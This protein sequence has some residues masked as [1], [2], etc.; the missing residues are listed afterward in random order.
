DAG[1]FN[2]DSATGAVTF[3]VAPDFEAPTDANG[4]NAY[5]VIVHANDGVHDTT[6]AVTISVTDTNDVEPTIT[7][8]ATGSEAENAST[9]NL[10]YQIIPTHPGTALSPSTTLFRSDAGQFNI[11]SA[12]GAVTF[13]VAPDFEAPTDANGDNAY[14]VIVHANDGVHD[15][16]QAVTIS[17]T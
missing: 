13:K 14:Q 10:L 17:V 5:Q 9:P 2:I 4:D 15:T 7:S 3:K 8:T 12:T 16:T 6:Q 11:D 1:Q